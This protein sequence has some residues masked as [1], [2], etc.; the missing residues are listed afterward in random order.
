MDELRV[1]KTR[2]KAE[3]ALGSGEVLTAELFLS[4]YSASHAGPERVSD[5]LGAGAQFFPAFV[6]AKG[7][8]VLINRAEVRYARIAAD[9]EPPDPDEEMGDATHHDVELSLK[10]GGRLRGRISYLRP[11]DRQRLGDFIN[12]PAPLLRLQEGATVAIVNKR[13]VEQVVHAGQ[14]TQ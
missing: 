3:L 10:G 8:I 14:A 11:A 13:A 9:A 12:E 2:L 7:A 1:P 5:L 6:A 4:S